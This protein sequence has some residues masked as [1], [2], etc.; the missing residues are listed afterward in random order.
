MRKYPLMRDF[1]S[2]CA[3]RLSPEVCWVYPAST[4][5]TGYSHYSDSG[6]DT[7]A[8]REAYRITYADPTL[9]VL[10]HCD[11]RAC[12]NPAHLFQGTYKD[13]YEDAKAKDRHSRGERNG[14]A[15][16]TPEAV[17]AIRGDTRPQVRI[18][19]DYGIRQT[20]V[21]EIKQHHLWSHL[22]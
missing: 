3:A 18:A 7:S 17:R 20:T 5:S 11:N 6:R 15:K 12:C 16:L 2:D 10:H 22:S 21:S 4:M 8:H 19:A 1:L 13:N 14:S 9:N